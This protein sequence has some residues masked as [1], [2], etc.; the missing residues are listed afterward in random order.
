MTDRRHLSIGFIAAIVAVALPSSLAAH[1]HVLVDAKSEVVFDAEGRMK[2]VRQ[3]WRFDPAFSAYAVQGLDT[4]GDG[5]YSEAELKPLAKVNVESLKEF[6][7]FT[8]LTIGDNELDFVEPKEYW[9]EIHGDQ[10]TLF[11]DL[12]LKAPIAVGPKTTLEVF[13]P[14]YFVAFTFVEKNPVILDGAPAGCNAV[15][16]PPHEL[17]DQTMALLGAQP[18]DQRELPPELADAAAGL[19]NLATITCP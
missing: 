18:K 15:Y 8:Y 1:P 6:D 19:A 16:H 9:L 17:D 12:P 2:S 14:E 5:E 10:L 7:F 3:S 4:D 11:Y 13:D